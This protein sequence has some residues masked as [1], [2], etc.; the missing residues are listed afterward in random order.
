MG[1]FVFLGFYITPT[2]K[3]SSAPQKFISILVPFRNEEKHLPALITSV[4]NLTYPS[5]LFEV[6]FVNDHS[7]DKGVEIINGSEIKSHHLIN[8]LGEGKKAAIAEGVKKAKGDIIAATDADCIVPSH[9]LEEIN[10]ASESSMVLGPVQLS[11]VKNALHLFQEMEWAALQSISASAVNWKIPFMS[12]GANMSYKK[13][14]FNGDALKKETASGDD[15]FLLEDFNKKKL[16]IRF[17]WNANSIVK[18][19]P[20]NSLRELTEQKVR[21]ASKTK[22]HTSKINMALGL[23]IACMN[24][25]VMF[26]T[27]YFPLADTTGYSFMII[28]AKLIVD[29]MIM[30]PYLILTK[31][32]YLVFFLSI[33]VLVYPFY[34]FYVLILSLRGKFTWKER[35]YHA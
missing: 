14:D 24:L 17:L 23:L 30:L 32:P 27:I 10:T 26:N 34:F 11:P 3:N 18:T 19:K 16:P 20:A 6:I 1:L 22:H 2:A 25:V 29:L 35:N 15:I 8:S 21:W 12:N 4:K 5:D 28:I 9:W 33:F 31:K 7:T 13:T